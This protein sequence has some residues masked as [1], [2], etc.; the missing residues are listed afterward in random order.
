MNKQ[1]AAY[2][3]AFKTAQDRAEFITAVGNNGIC[4]LLQGMQYEGPTLW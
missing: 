4:F 1:Q 2:P 3:I